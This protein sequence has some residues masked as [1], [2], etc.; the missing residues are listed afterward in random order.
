MNAVTC[1]FC[2]ELIE[3]NWHVLANIDRDLKHGCNY[4]VIELGIIC[5]IFRNMFNKMLVYDIISL[6]HRYY[7]L[8]NTSI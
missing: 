4:S 7:H 3:C 5:I 6:N 8:Y 2:A 1:V